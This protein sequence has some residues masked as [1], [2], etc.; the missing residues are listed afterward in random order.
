MKSRNILKH[1]K[2]RSVIKHFHHLKTTVHS[3][4]QPLT[5]APPIGLSDDESIDRLNGHDL[6]SHYT[7]DIIKENTVF[8]R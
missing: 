2:K 5:Q 1:F 6:F 7:A 4:T 3:Y 8:T